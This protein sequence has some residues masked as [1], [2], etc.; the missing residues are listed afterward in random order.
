[1]RM[2]LAAGL[3]LWAAAGAA[4]ADATLTYK[5]EPRTGQAQKLKIDISGFFARIESSAAPGGWWLFQ[6]GKF[7]PV[8]RVDDKAQTWTRLTA[9]PQARLGPA[10]RSAGTRPGTGAAI[11]TSAVAPEAVAK[12]PAGRGQ[13][14][15]GEGSEGGATAAAATGPAPAFEPTDEM[16]NIAGVRCRVV[17]ELRGDAPAVAHCMANK[18]SLGLT[19]RELRTLSRTFEMARQQ[20][21]GWLGTA[22]ADEEFVSVRSGAGERGGS[23]MLES[24]STAALP[25]GYLRVPRGYGEVPREAARSAPAAAPAQ[26][27][28]DKTTADGPGSS[29][30]D[31]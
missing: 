18:A 14:A 1:M 20:G 30:P 13:A 28:S 19:E 17:K 31:P 25:Q 8:Y 16:D 11:D 24:V 29:A 5:L 7:F 15:G 3:L 2:Q 9:A 4:V 27:D 21:L 6:A 22:T 10:D 23:L 12:I 26:Q